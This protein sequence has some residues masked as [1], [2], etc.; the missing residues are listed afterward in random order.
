MDAGAR[1]IFTVI[2]QVY[3]ACHNDGRFILIQEQKRVLFHSSQRH[4]GQES[5]QLV[6]LKTT[7]K[8]HLLQQ[9]K[10]LGNPVEGPAFV[11]FVVL[12]EVYVVA[13][14]VLLEQS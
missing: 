5:L 11:G 10:H 1:H 4:L 2:E 7:E 8:A 6:C 3:L 9:V 13:R 12:P 14:L